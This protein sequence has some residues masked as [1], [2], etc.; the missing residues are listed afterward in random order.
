MKPHLRNFEKKCSSRETGKDPIPKA[1]PPPAPSARSS[2]S[3]LKLRPESKSS[4]KTEKPVA[5][6]APMTKA[7][8]TGLINVGNTCFM[9]SGNAFSIIGSM[10]LNLC[11]IFEFEWW[12]SF[13]IATAKVYENKSLENKAKWSNVYPTFQRCA[14]IFYHEVRATISIRRKTSNSN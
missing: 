9:A 14:I 5:T 1:P 12:K 7:G 8:Y 13:L 4:E 2:S 6:V 3:T 10:K 11:S